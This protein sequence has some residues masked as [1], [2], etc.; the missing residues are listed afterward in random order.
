MISLWVAE[1]LGGRR[2]EGGG[3]ST[4]AG[5]SVHGV[6]AAIDVQLLEPL[7]N[8]AEAGTLVGVLHRWQQGGRQVG[9]GGQLAA[10]GS[11]RAARGSMGRHMRMALRG[12]E[13]V[14]PGRWVRAVS[15]V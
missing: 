13:H 12:G 10:G 4:E 15:E 14:Q 9:G 6:H 1:A 2:E 11:R 3:G 5:G 8:Q 7:Q